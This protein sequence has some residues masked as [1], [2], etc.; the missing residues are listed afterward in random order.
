MHRQTIDRGL[1]EEHEYLLFS[2]TFDGHQ[3]INLDVFLT[4][5]AMTVAMDADTSL[6]NFL[7]TV[8]AW[9][10][11]KGRDTETFA[12]IDGEWQEEQPKNALLREDET[13][14]FDFHFYD[15]FDYF[16]ASWER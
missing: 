1:K 5:G 12:L 16:N 14:V 11:V 8:E 9:Y 15:N 7:E 2:E 4:E 3:E 10:P 6:R 13:D